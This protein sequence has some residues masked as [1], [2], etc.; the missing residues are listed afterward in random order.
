MKARSFNKHIAM[1]SG[2]TVKVKVSV[3][4]YKEDDIHYAYCPA[5][6]I[7]GYGNTDEEAKHS[8]EVM[9]DEI[10]KDAIKEGTIFALLESCGWKAA[11]PPKTSEMIPRVKELADIVDNRAYKSVS[12]EIIIPAFA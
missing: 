7:L 3:F 11:V 9:I 6:D 4:F 10:L 8:F 12:T 2:A 1:K 5:L